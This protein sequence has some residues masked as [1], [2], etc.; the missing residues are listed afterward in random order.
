METFKRP[1]VIKAKYQDV[2]EWYLLLNNSPPA[3]S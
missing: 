2:A 1:G 3:R